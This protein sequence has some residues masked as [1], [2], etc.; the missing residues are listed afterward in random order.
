MANVPLEIRIHEVEKSKKILHNPRW[1]Q[2][3]HVLPGDTISWT[4]NGAAFRITD[5][6]HD[7]G[8]KCMTHPEN[9]FRVALSDKVFAKGE[10]NV[11]SLVKDEASGGKYKST[12]EI[13]QD[14]NSTTPLE[15]LDPHIYVGP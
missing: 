11:S 10:I 7:C 12:W 2:V 5:V 13:Y 1:H 9:P 8:D 15:R 3:H 6:R 4:C 14:V